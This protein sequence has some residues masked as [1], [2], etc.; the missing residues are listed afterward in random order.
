MKI[1]A[2]FVTKVIA[3]WPSKTAVQAVKLKVKILDGQAEI[4]KYAK[5]GD[6]AMD[7]VATSVKDVYGDCGTLKYAQYGT[8]L[9]IEIP[10]GH[11]GLVFPRSSISDSAHSLSNSVGVIDSGYRGEWMVK[12]RYAFAGKHY[13][14]GERI[15]QFMVI[16]VPEMQV[17]LSS[18]LSKSDRGSGGFGSTGK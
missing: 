3:L 15:A 10:P 11:V 12:M 1:L 2:N 13:K 9:A 7:L 8:G 18:E 6:A 4:P 16:P 5:P 17:E 14:V